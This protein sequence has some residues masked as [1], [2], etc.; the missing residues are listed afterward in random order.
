M[1]SSVQWTAFTSTIYTLYS[2]WE[3]AGMDNVHA[4]VPDPPDPPDPHVL[5]LLDPEAEPIVRGMDP[6]PDHS[7]SKQN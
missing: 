1:Y 2:H 7:I 5:V 4:S 6:D 3:G